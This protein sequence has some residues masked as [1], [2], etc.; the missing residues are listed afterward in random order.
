MIRSARPLPALA[1]ALLLAACASYAPQ[2]LARDPALLAP[3]VASILQARADAIPRPWLAPV[4]ID[5]QAPLDDAAVATLA[6]VNGPDLV[7]LRTRAG[8]A[9]AQAFAAGLLP[10]PTFSLGA[11]KV[12]RGPDTLLNLSAALGFDLNALRT[13]ALTRAQAN[14]QARSVRLDLAWAEWQAA[15]QARLQA[16]RI[17]A[18]E[19]QL[20]PLRDSARS[21]AQL[22]EASQRAAA[23]GD[24]TA[25]AAQA[26]RLAVLDAQT[27]LR[28]LEQDLLTARQ[29]LNRLLGLP[30][31]TPLALADTP[32]NA[33]QPAPLEALFTQAIAQRSDLA[34]LRAGYDAQEAALH[35]AILQQFPS[36]NLSLTGNRDSAGNLLLG[37]AIDFTLPLWNRSRGNIAVETATRASLRAEYAARLFQTRA[38]LASARE[39]LLLALRQ[40]A[41]A[42]ADAPALRMQAEAAQA[43]AHRGDLAQAAADALAQA[44]RDRALLLAQLE[45]TIAEQRIALELLIGAP[46]EETP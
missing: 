4:R 28:T 24:I 38:D 40:R 36:L 6:V 7:A 18:Y 13:R 3:P 17:R 26:Q 42:Q 14:A 20:P 43:A 46:T 27:R 23:R 19:R 1:L 5:L 2:P 32:M 25:E 8:I 12:L 41:A 39:A 22:A 10:D 33:A 35:K 15:G 45:Q 9:E 21:A 30:P 29:T 44:W 11:D 37:P 34:A 16:A 31:Q